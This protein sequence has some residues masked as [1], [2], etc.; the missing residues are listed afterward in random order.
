M[1]QGKKKCKEKTIGDMGELLL[2]LVSTLLVVVVAVVA[3]VNVYPF[4]LMN[5]LV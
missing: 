2:F 1:D 5:C 4:T 3:H